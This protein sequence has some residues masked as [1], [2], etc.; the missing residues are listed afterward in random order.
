[1]RTMQ[2]PT[3]ATRPTKRPSR[4][5]F[6]A[7]DSPSHLVD[8]NEPASGV[9]VSLRRPTLRSGDCSARRACG[10]DVADLA[11]LALPRS[12]DLDSN[13]EWRGATSQ[14]C[15]GW[16]SPAR[17]PSASARGYAP[18]WADKSARRS[19][20]WVI[21]RHSLPVKLDAP[22]RYLRVRASMRDTGAQSTE[23]NPQDTTDEFHLTAIWPHCTDSTNVRICPRAASWDH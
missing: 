23:R 10:D 15:P 11:D 8:A 12:H 2:R 18:P 6:L 5:F 7:L 16:H 1:M 13:P 4:L 21:G 20:L 19:R 9:A 3:S 22:Q 17:F 14:Q